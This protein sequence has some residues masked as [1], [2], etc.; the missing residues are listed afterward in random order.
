MDWC[1]LP[2]HDVAFNELRNAI[3]ADLQLRYFYSSLDTTIEVDASLKG[4]GA[5]LLQKGKP[6]A[7]SSKALTDVE[8]RY[9]NIEREL[10][11]V[12]F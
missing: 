10:L 1:W 4:L 2:E 12:V 5:A 6:V 9:A 8:S 11:A 3:D 7:F